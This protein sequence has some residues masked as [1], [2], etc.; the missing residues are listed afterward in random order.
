M[1][2]VGRQ[3]CSRN[4]SYVIAFLHAHRHVLVQIA[5]EQFRGADKVEFER[6]FQ[7]LGS[8][9]A[10][11]SEADRGWVEEPGDIGKGDL[12]DSL[13][14]IHITYL[15]DHAEARYAPCA[16][17]VEATTLLGDELLGIESRGICRGVDGQRRFVSGRDCAQGGGQGC[18][19]EQCV[20]ACHDGISLRVSEGRDSKD[21]WPTGPV[22][23]WKTSESATLGTVVPVEGFS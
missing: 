14:Q 4:C 16:V 11:I 13:L 8:G 21:T 10:E 3:Q 9:I 15:L 12:I 18:G 5:L 6:L 20:K 23:L 17:V 1:S 7:Y 2:L 22:C 19:E